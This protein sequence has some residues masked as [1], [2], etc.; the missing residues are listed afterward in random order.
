MLKTEDRAIFVEGHLVSERV[1]QI[2]AAI[3]DYEPELDVR[4]IPPAARSEG[5]A[6]F[7]I[8]HRPVGS[9]EYVLFY[10]PKDEDF[11]EK[12]L[13]RIIHNDQRN[14][15][16]TYGE[17]EAWEEAQKR[18]QRQAYLDKM[19]EAHDLARFVLRSPL[20][21]MTLPDGLVI[22]DFGGGRLG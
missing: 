11:D 1:S 16:R 22:N 15:E 5:D 20:H 7:A 3:K 6:A 18:V 19:E 21:K 13:Y 10:V 8:I 4:W 9:P 14:G 2:V 12:V 17:V